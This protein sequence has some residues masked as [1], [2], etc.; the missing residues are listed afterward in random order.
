MRKPV[1]IFMFFIF[2]SVNILGQSPDERIGTL[3][4]N[5]DYFELDR[6]YPLVK[7][8]LHPALKYLGKALLEDAFS[9]PADAVETVGYIVQ[10]LQAELG[11]ENILGMIALQS[12]NLL[13]LGRYTEAANTLSGLLGQPDV[14]TYAQPQTISALRELNKKAQ[15]LKNYPKSEIIRP[16]KDCTI[17]I[18]KDTINQIR[19]DVEINGKKSPFIFDTGADSQGFVSMD[20]AKENGIRII[21]DSILTGGVTHSAY[22]KIGFVDSLKI[23]DIV[24]KNISFLVADKA[25]ITYKDSVIGRV[26]AVLGRYFMDQIGE[27]HIYPKERKIVFPAKESDV[28][29]TGRNLVLLNGQPYIEATADNK[30]LQFHFDTGGGIILSAKYYNENKQQVESTGKKDSIGIGGFGGAKRIPSYKIPEFT[31]SIANTHCILPNVTVLT[32]PLMIGERDGTLGTD[33]INKFDKVIFNFR[34]MFFKIEK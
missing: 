32:E 18:L 23:G 17:P 20:F 22:T 1:A 9:D 33:F 31:L 19:I 30:K 14:I 7:D 2:I 11:F 26:S 3:I 21:G 25:E 16:D 8:S 13:K 12:N 28:P 34:K 27:F 29:L 4:N 24:Y 6:Q 10:N 5:T 15:I